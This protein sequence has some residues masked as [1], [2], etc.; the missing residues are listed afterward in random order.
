L[1]SGDPALVDLPLW[2]ADQSEHLARHVALEA[3]NGRATD[4]V[5]NVSSILDI[6]ERSDG[7][8][9]VPALA[10]VFGRGAAISRPA[11]DGAGDP[12]RDR[13]YGRSWRE[14]GA[15]LIR[16]RNRQWVS[17]PIGSDAVRSAAILNGPKGCSTPE[18]SS[19]SPGFR[20]RAI[21]AVTCLFAAM[22]A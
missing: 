19:P 12:P 18:P 5:A 10:L 1:S 20:P 16:T 22:M 9:I 11:D 2:V 14:N 6:V 17:A 21:G 15:V 13:P 3:P 8:S 7:V 4:E